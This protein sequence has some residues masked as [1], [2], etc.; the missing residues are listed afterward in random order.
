MSNVPINVHGGRDAVFRDVFVAIW[1]RF[2]V[3][4]INTGDGN[5]FVAKGDVTV[6]TADGT[7]VRDLK[8]KT[9][10]ALLE[11]EKKLQFFLHKCTLFSTCGGLS[12]LLCQCCCCCPALFCWPAGLPRPWKCGCSSLEQFPLRGSSETH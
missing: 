9:A 1:T 12:P 11:G 8:A 2:T 7:S 4:R 3:H 5:S 10:E 6:N